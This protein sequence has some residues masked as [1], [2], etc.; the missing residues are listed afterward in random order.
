MPPLAGRSRVTRNSLP[1]EDPMSLTA[2]AQQQTRVRKPAAVRTAVSEMPPVRRYRTVV[3][4]N[5]RWAGFRYRADDI[6]ISTPAKCGTT[7]MQTCLLYT[8]P[9]HET[10][11]HL[12]CRLL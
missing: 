8:S 10:P 7:W 4:D 5:A 3:S 12:V 6:V 9:S 11:E 2:P 1:P